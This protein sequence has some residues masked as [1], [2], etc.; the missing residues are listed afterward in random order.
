VNANFFRTHLL[1]I[2]GALALA[3]ML[4]RNTGIDHALTAF[5]YDAATHRFPAHASAALELFGHRFAKTAVT[6]VWIALLVMA[7]STHLWPA[8][9]SRLTAH[10][11]A[12]WAAVAGMAMGPTVVVALKGL[13]SYHCPWDLREFGGAAD[14]VTNW[15]V[16]AAEVGHCFPGGHAAAGF[17]L[18][19]LY[20]LACELERPQLARIALAGTLI[21]GVGFSAVRM[22]QGAHFLS[23]NLW[24]AAICWAMAALAFLPLHVQRSRLVTT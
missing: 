24:A 4:V 3:A 7:A 14:F 18:V 20:F 12:L 5:F 11:A 19:A 10:R 17:C 13:N 22:A 15:F 23:H 21:A 6:M 8:W 16:S 2:P 1:V 9:R